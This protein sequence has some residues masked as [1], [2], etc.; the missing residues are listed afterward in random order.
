M[1]GSEPE[2]VYGEIVWHPETDADDSA[3][4]TIRFGGGVLASILC[5]QR[6]G[7]LDSLEIIGTDGYLR[8]EWPADTVEVRS[9]II[10]EYGEPTSLDYE[11][12][13][14]MLRAEMQA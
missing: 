3:A 1:L 6:T 9:D 12:V 10:E 8:S 5:S 4:Y 7:S 2:Q 11:D 14:P 13:T